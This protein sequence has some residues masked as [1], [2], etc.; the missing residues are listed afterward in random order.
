MLKLLWLIIDMCWGACALLQPADNSNSFFFLLEAVKFVTEKG[1]QLEGKTWGNTSETVFATALKNTCFHTCFDSPSLAASP[2]LSIS[3]TAVKPRQKLFG[4][5]S[6]SIFTA[7]IESN[8][9][10]SSTQN[11]HRASLPKA[12]L[13]VITKKMQRWAQSII[14]NFSWRKLI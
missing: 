14:S 13:S 2:S 6:V 5:D 11:K 8:Q 12:P 3:A 4:S 10:A 9:P 1:L 7:A